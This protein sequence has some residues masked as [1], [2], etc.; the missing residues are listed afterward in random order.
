[1]DRLK[2]TNSVP[3]AQAD[4]APATGTAQYATS[5]NPAGGV[6]ATLFPAY[7]WNMIQDELMAILSAAGVTPDDTKWSQVIEALQTMFQGAKALSAIDSGAVNAYSMTLTPAPSALTAGMQVTLLDVLNTPTGA[8]TLNVNGTGALPINLNGAA[9]AGGEFSLGDDV[10]FELN[11]AGTAWNLVFSTSGL[12]AARQGSASQAFQVGDATSNSDAVNLG[13]A[14]AA[15]TLGNASKTFGTTYT[16]SGTTIRKVSICINPASSSGSVALSMNGAAA[17]T[18][19]NLLGGSQYVF[20][21]FDVF[22]G[23]T[24]LVTSNGSVIS[25]LER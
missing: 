13:Q 18:L 17:V 16:N 19:C 9:L 8:S 11:N 14:G 21:S 4:T 22:P 7:A 1:M 2:A 25:W 10:I 12:F 24:Y 6:P 20:V 5:G 15:Q 3:L 23:E